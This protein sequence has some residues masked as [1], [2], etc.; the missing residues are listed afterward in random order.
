MNTNE[1]RNDEVYRAVEI[2]ISHGGRR[3]EFL[4]AEE[5]EEEIRM[6]EARKWIEKDI[7]RHQRERER[8]ALKAKIFWYKIAA[9]MIGVILLAF[10]YFGSKISGEGGLIIFLPIAIA[11]LIAPKPDDF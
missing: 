3:I 1:A 9:R 10:T 2:D 11:F 5:F 4:N 7:R 8:R 6:D